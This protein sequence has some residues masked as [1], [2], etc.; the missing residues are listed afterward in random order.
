M[1]HDLRSLLQCRI[2]AFGDYSSHVYGWLRFDGDSRICASYPHPREAFYQLRGSV[3]EFLFEDGDSVTTRLELVQRQPLLFHG[4]TVGLSN[5]LY[6]RE[7][8]FLPSRHRLAPATSLRPAVLVNSVP[9]SGT[10]FLQRA[11][12]ELGFIPTDLHLGNAC[13]HDNRGRPRDASIHRT[14]WVHEVTL[15]V[16][17]LPPFLSS[18][19]VTVG[20]VDDAGVLH[21][22]MDAGVC[23]LFVVRD[24][25]AILWSLF[26]FKLA[27]VAPRDDADR[28]WRSCPSPLEQFMGFLA[29]YWERDILHICN[30]CRFF[31]SLVNVLVLR[32]EDLLKGVLP[33]PSVQLLER[34]LAGSGGASAF[35]AAVTMARNAPTPTLT[36]TLPHRPTFTAEEEQ[37]IRRL[38][39]ALVAGSSLAEVNAL[40]GYR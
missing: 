30:C 21:A 13:L 1:T 22:F 2:F 38:I 6:L 17:L 19:S 23:V 10:Y 39:D 29:Y 24:L 20:H 14:P 37:E 36:H 3:V 31:A 7:V 25:R 26:R 9:K 18:G 4:S 5:L 34:Q 32:Y 28:H 27:V 11:F 12:Q 15:S 35:L 16:A 8:L 33:E 40:F